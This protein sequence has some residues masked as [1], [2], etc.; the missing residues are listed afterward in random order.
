MQGATR[1][2]PGAHSHEELPP[3]QGVYGPT[4]WGR[5]HVTDEESQPE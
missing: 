2:C 1:L 4:V 3:L 5:S